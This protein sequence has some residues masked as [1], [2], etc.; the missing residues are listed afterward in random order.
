MKLRFSSAFIIALIAARRYRGA[1][2]DFRTFRVMDIVAIDIF[3]AAILLA[4]TAF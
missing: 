3:N 1:A 4:T 2:R